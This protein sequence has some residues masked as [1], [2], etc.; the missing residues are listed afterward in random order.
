MADCIAAQ[1][2]REAAVTGKTHQD[3]TL[4]RIKLLGAF[5]MAMREAQFSRASHVQLVKGS[6]AGAISHVSQTFREHGRPDPTLDDN[7]NWIPS[8]TGTESLQERGPNR[9]TPKG[10][11]DVSYIRTCQAP[12]LR[13]RQ[14]YRSAHRTRHLLCIQV[15]RVPKSHTG[16][17]TSDTSDSA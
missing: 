16:R 5:A 8:T 2:A 17:T 3:Q 4:D 10:N 7:G 9:E 6:I 11:T 1:A 14:G 15:L 12:D 13:I